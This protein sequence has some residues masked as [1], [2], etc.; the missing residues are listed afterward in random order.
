MTIL[1]L[2]C[3]S[4]IHSPEVQAALVRINIKRFKSADKVKK[5]DFQQPPEHQPI[6]ISDETVRR[7]KGV[8]EILTG[9]AVGGAL[10]ASVGLLGLLGGP[11][12]GVTIAAGFAVGGGIGY[13]LATLTTFAH[14]T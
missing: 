8:G 9:T 3:L 14:S 5:V 13:F 11:L 1:W 7:L 10:G 12:G 4:T 6:V 2:Y